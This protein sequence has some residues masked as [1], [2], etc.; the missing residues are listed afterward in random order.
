[1]KTKKSGVFAALAVVLLIAAVLIASCMDPLNTGLSGS[2]DKIGDI[3]PP[4]GKRFVSI[5]F[6]G[7]ARTIM[8][9][10]ATAAAAD[11]TVFVVNFTD[12]NTFDSTT[13][14]PATNVIFQATAAGVPDPSDP[15]RSALENLQLARFEVTDEETYTIKVDAYERYTALGTNIAATW[16]DDIE[17]SGALTVVNVAL[18]A[19][20]AGAG[21]GWFAWDLSLDPTITTATM[22]FTQI[23]GGAAK[24]SEVAT[25]ANTTG[26]A[27]TVGEYRVDLALSSSKTIGT[28]QEQYYP[29]TRSYVLHIYQGM[30]SLFDDTI[31]ALLSMAHEVTF[32]DVDGA[33]DTENAF[34]LHGELLN[35]TT[36]Y[37]YY[38]SSTYE[39]PVHTSGLAF[40][41]WQT[42]DGSSDD[43]G[44]PVDI[45]T[46]KVY[47]PQSIYAKWITADQARVAITF[48]MVDGGN[49]MTVSGNTITQADFMT[50]P[51]LLS[52]GVTGVPTAENIDYE[53]RYSGVNNAANIIST[54]DTFALTWN[55][56]NSAT[57]VYIT[58]GIHNVSVFITVEQPA[59]VTNTYSKAFTFTVTP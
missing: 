7:S 4:E 58:P 54:T 56:A 13:D 47:K 18:A 42:K 26:V 28:D 8:P 24:A 21:T 32:E 46:Y 5:N 20:K 25:V 44:D 29:E 39:D 41:S 36:R 12:T 34:Y 19:T 40:G 38:I 35:A 23:T 55:P 33:G 15:A 22:S 1:M 16:T 37:P 11:F 30:T 17:M 31:G 51:Y 49:G 43:W 9:T 59:G 6:G 50:S 57:D 14:T 2:K 53:W 52:F 10:A 45:A 27:M 48:S 3:A